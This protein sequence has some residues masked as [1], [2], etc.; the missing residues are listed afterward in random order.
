MTDLQ[1]GLLVIGIAAVVGV[2]VYNRV[3]ER[4][5]RREAQRAFGAQH[6]DALLDEAPRRRE[7]TLDSAPRRA[8]Q[9]AGLQPSEQVDY[10]IDI[11]GAPL[12][13]LR[14][15]WAAIE[16]R[17]AKRAMLAEKDA[18][19][20]AA[21][22]M[23]SRA[24]VVSEAELR[25]FRSQ[26]QALAAAHGATVSAPQLRPALEAAHKLDRECA[27]VDVQIA[28]HVLGVA[29]VSAD[30]QPFQV[31]RRADGVTLLLDV[32][33]TPD[34]SRSYEAMVRAAR[35]LGG[36]LV[37]DNGNALDDRALAAI[38]VEVEAMRARLAELGIEPGSPLAL[39]LF[40]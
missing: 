30:A 31:T 25:E 27:E 36:R 4:A 37:D 38:G 33:R 22:Q 39:R 15:R 6:A 26:V 24:G 5:T 16:Q 35:Q 20:Q 10:I 29:E 40:S 14:A 23:V 8:P 21:L 13:A 32:P 2:F 11:Q 17:F 12:A 34:L 28:L 1:L 19:L 9:P 7:P 18:K 3:Q